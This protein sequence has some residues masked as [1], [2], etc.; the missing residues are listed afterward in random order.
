M[1]RPVRPGAGPG[2]SRVEHRR[3]S[4]RVR[5]SA[6]ASPVDLRRAADA[7]STTSTTGST[8]SW[9]W[10]AKAQPAALRDA[11][12]IKTAYAYGLRRNELARLD[13]ADLRPNPHEPELG[14]LRLGPRPVRQGGGAAACRAAAPCSRSRS[15]TGSST[16]CASGSRRSGRCSPPPTI[17]RC[18]SPNGSPGSRRGTSMSGSPRP[19]TRLGAGPEPDAALPAALL[20]DAPGRVRLPRAVR[21]R[22]GRARVPPRPP[23]STPRSPT[24]SRTRHCAGR[25]PA[26]TQRPRQRAAEA[27]R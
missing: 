22:T 18:G 15:S 20:R 27:C 9:R 17:R 6:A 13:V 3:A 24:T 1:P 14:H 5:G 21:H 19:A 26:S 8:G 4:Q 2:V 10:A 7:S 16:G 12:M 25:C 23:R 11:L